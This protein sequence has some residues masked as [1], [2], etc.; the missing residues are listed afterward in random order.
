MGSLHPRM[1]RAYECG[2][3]VAFELT[4]KDFVS[5]KRDNKQLKPISSFPSVDRDFAF[6]VSESV[7][8]DLFVQTL[9]K[10]KDIPLQKITLFN[11][12]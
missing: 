4:L 8:S 7:P 9:E 10:V 11:L 6:V 2:A 1:S 5:V 3:M 12:A